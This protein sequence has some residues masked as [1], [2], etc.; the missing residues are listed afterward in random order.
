MKNK[1]IYFSILKIE[2]LY[3]EIQVLK[4][5]NTTAISKNYNGPNTQ[6]KTVV[7]KLPPS[8]RII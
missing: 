7:Y 5:F 1:I 2:E 6:T 8:I 4:K 3:S